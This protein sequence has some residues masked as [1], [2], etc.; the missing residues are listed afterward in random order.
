M[1]RPS[2]LRSGVWLLLAAV[3]P[4]CAYT[5][6]MESRPEPAL[7]ELPN[8]TRISTPDEARV[9]WA[10]FNKQEVTVTA[11]GYRPLTLDLRQ[12]HVRFGRL[13]KRPFRRAKGEVEF[14]L[15]PTHGTTGTWGEADVPD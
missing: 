11:A 3:L 9:R 15:V 8:G 13:W 14:L 1:K 7:V 4:G 2:A 5:L 10:P 6:A 12:D